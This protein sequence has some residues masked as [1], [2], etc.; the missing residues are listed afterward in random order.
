MN[1]NKKAVVSGVSAA[2]GKGSGYETQHYR[3]GL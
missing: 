1:L 2:A 3:T